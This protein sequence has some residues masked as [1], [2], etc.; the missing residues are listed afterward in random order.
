LKAQA[1]AGRFRADAVDGGRRHA[2]PAVEHR[3][4]QVSRRLHGA[5]ARGGVALALAAQGGA[6]GHQTAGEGLELG[7]RGGVGQGRVE[8][9][10]QRGCC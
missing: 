5:L 2:Q 9:W 3:L 6:A 1:W 4:R 7:A 8:R 10:R